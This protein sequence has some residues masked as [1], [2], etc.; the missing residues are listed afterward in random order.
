MYPPFLPSVHNND[1][2]NNDVFVKRDPLS[3]YP[4]FHP[5]VHNNDDNN[6]DVFVSKART[7]NIKVGL[8][9]QYRNLI[10]TPTVETQVNGGKR[11]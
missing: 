11:Q 9:A 5:S 6:N 2:N 4:P 7:S 8:G 10:L 3:M 1:G